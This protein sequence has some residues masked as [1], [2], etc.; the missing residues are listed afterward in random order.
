MQSTPLLPSL[1]G[2][3]WPEVVA[4]DWVLSIGQRDLDCLLMHNWIVWNR[5]A[6]MYK[7]GFGM[8]QAT[9]VGMIYDLIIDYLLPYIYIYIY[10]YIDRER[11]IQRGKEKHFFK[12]DS[13]LHR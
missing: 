6:Y 3:L 8:K 10:I 1:P 5:T 4:S 7:N 2:S 9:L 11:K 12:K 13:D